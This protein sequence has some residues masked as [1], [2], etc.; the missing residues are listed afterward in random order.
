MICGYHH[1]RK[2]PYINIFPY[3][4]FALSLNS[5][6]QF[7][8]LFVFMVSVNKI[9]DQLVVDKQATINHNKPSSTNRPTTQL[10]NQPT[11]MFIPSQDLL[12]FAESF[13]SS[14][15]FDKQPR[16]VVDLDVDGDAQ[17]LIRSLGQVICRW[18]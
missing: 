11:K 2:H 4:P 6:F 18:R 16:S 5:F 17:R 12:S 10:T 13:F 3:T 7:L 1:L 9:S 15:N 14:E 8:L